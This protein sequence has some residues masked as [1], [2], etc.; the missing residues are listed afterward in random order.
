MII[1]LS[2]FILLAICVS[3]D[4]L[5]IGMTYGLKNTKISFSAKWILLFIS[6]FI[7]SL[8][9]LVG[10]TISSFFPVT[11]TNF[12][13]SLLLLFLGIWMIL[14]SFKMKKKEVIKKE[15]KMY[16]FFICF[17][18]IT[19][20]I[21]RN[22]SSSDLDHSNQI[23]S[24]EAI[25]LGIALSLDAVGIGIGSS[26]IGFSSFLFPLLVALFQ[27]LFLSLGSY[28]GRKVQKSFF[29][30][31]NIWSIFSGILLIIIA[32]NKCIFS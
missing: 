30:P 22:P 6:F 15:E 13:G 20:Q 19:I 17:L 27:L 14:P 9:L 7:T 4:S 10:K 29:L 3:I 1:M 21:I 24:K 23:D 26:M 12:I 16:Q 5:G 11:I 28:I 2:S 18:G 25:Y 31:D 8:S 32:I